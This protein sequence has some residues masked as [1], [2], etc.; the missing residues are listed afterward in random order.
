MPTSPANDVDRNE[1]KVRSME[2]VIVLLEQA[3]VECRENLA[4]LQTLRS[5]DRRHEGRE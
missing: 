4:S 3:L 5:V 2:R 1:A